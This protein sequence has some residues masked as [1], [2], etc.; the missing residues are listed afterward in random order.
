MLVRADAS[1]T[2]GTGHVMR[3]LALAQAWR[4]A[5]GQ[6]FFAMAPGTAALEQRLKSEGIEVLRVAARPGSSQDAG[7]TVK[8]ARRA[9]ICWVVVDG[10]HFG[11]NYQ[12]RLKEA[13]LHVLFID[14]H[15]HADHYCA[16]LVLNQNLHAAEDLYRSRE[17]YTRLLLGARYILLRP[18][19]LKWRGWKREIPKVGRKLLVTL[20]GADPG[21]TTLRVIQAI[22]RVKA[23]RLEAVV[24]AGGN[25]PHYEKL[26]SAARNSIARIRL[27]RDA[28]NMPELMAWADIGVSGAG[29][30]SWELAFMGLPSL[31]LVQAENQ[32]AIA[33]KLAAMG[34]AVNLGW[35]RTRAVGEI[36]RSITR[37]LKESKMRFRLNRRSQILVDGGGTA[38]VLS[39][40]DIGEPLPKLRRVRE[41]DCEIVWQWANDPQVRAASFSSGAI[42]WKRHAEW[43]RSK[44]DS[45]ACL[46]YIAT[47]GSE[48]PIGQIRYDLEGDQAV[49]SISLDQKQRG[50]GYGTNLIRLSARE[51]FDSRP[52]AL[53]HAYVKPET[54]RPWP[55]SKKLDTEIS[56]QPASRDAR[57]CI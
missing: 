31:L 14:D 37:L 36:G 12:Q 34:A 53:V 47:T 42:P 41:E 56:G 57:L 46:F 10:Y 20:G 15:G 44:L 33:E 50:H 18:E 43:F 22:K 40:M 48:A 19:F 5:G 7:Y 51:L 21:N 8:F 25:N 3:C 16:D 54:D 39:N 23:H 1:A 26:Q 24:L 52:V 32:A 30:T 45:G 29:T 55:H 9:G 38:R 27:E 17:S 49:V 4:A 13:G 28:T 11:S 6:P 35:A 2:I